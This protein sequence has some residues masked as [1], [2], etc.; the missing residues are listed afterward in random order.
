MQVCS[1]C[2]IDKAD[3]EFHYKN[4]AKGK[5][6]KK[7]KGCTLLYLREHYQQNKA[8]YVDRALR[9]NP[10]SSKRFKA[11]ARSLKLKCS[12]CPEDHPAAL[13]FHHLDPSQKEHEPAKITSRK[14]LLEE[15]KKCIV[16]CSNCHRK[17][18]WNQRAADG[19]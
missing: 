14:K 19:K 5:L 8:A 16:L 15:I 18:H 11:F 10:E 7:C 12:N 6:S 17:L 2:G 1:T 4:K 3:S 9:S 13:D